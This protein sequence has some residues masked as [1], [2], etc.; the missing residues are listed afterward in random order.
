MAASGEQEKDGVSEAAA[1]ILS[2]LPDGSKS[3][4]ISIDSCVVRGE[5][6]GEREG[7]A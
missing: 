2:G 1:S 3:L 4:F 6:V 5:G 7:C